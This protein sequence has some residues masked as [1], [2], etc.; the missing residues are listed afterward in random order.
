[1]QK[2]HA[3]QR[4]FKPRR[5]VVSGDPIAESVSPAKDIPQPKK[6]SLWQKLRSLRMEGD[7][8]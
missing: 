5:I 4:V 6:Q 1:M 2:M 7:S 8:K 3:H